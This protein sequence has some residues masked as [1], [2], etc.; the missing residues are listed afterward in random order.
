MRKLGPETLN[1][2]QSLGAIEEWRAAKTERGSKVAADLADCMK[3]FVEHG[4]DLGQAISYAE[5]ILKQ[6]G[7]IQLMTGHKAKGLEFDNAEK[8]EN[9]GP[10]YHLDPWLCRDD[11]QDQNLRYVIQTRS[12]NRYFEINS[13]NVR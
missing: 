8:M 5:H 10:V 4:R 6:T 7:T 12:A 9:P 11:E 1:R 3:V 2:E 13:S